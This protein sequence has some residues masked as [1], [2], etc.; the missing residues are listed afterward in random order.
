MGAK[1]GNYEGSTCIQTFVAVEQILWDAGKQ[2]T[3]CGVVAV[4]KAWF[5]SE[6]QA[7]RFRAEMRNRKR[8]KGESLQKLYQDVLPSDVVGVSGRIVDIIGYRGT[9]RLPGSLS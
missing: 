6:F 8:D 4:L 7:E 2:S 1:L 3:V 9:K 5:G